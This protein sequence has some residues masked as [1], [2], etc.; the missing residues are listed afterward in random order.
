MDPYCSPNVLSARS[1]L[2]PLDAISLTDNVLDF[3]QIL[4][5]ACSVLGAVYVNRLLGDCRFRE[6]TR[7]LHE[8]KELLEDMQ[9]QERDN[10]ERE[11]PG[12]LKATLERVKKFEALLKDLKVEYQL[13]SW[14]DT[15]NP[16]S[17]VN[18]LISSA[19]KDIKAFRDDLATTTK[20]LR[21]DNL[22]RALAAAA[23][24]PTPAPAVDIMPDVVNDPPDVEMLPITDPEAAAQIAEVANSLERQAAA[25]R[26]KLPMSR[27]NGHRLADLVT[28][29][30]AL[31]T[32]LFHHMRSRA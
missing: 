28:G 18:G 25:L 21:A 29:V 9:A 15:Y 32:T 16:W 11:R 14:K 31:L 19:R 3:V 23:G 10:L 13:S 24:T 6:M 5:T 20:R 8:W 12:E 22:R 30:Q 2:G 7:I 17:E 4:G 26:A 27:L 1:N